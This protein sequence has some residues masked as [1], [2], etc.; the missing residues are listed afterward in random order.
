MRSRPLIAILVAAATLLPACN[1]DEVALS[2]T[3]TLIGPATTG[4]VDVSSTTSTSAPDGTSTTLRSETV[5]SYEIV[6]RIA[7]DNGDILYVVIPPGAYTDIDL[8]NFIQ[9]LR[10]SNPGLWGVEVFDDPEAALA[11]QVAEEDRTESDQELLDG[12]HLVSLVNGDT[13]RFQGPLSD[14]GEY[15][16]AS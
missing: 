16:L 10:E 2:T 5:S 3:S 13:L 1:S 9:D 6:V 4:G 14:F 8:E 12:H 11:F 7:H 15:V